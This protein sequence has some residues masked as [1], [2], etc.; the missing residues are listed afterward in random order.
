VLLNAILFPQSSCDS[1]V[2]SPKHFAVLFFH[3]LH[4]LWEEML[5]I[6]WDYTH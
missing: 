3:P 5:L 2:A 6:P 1:H 4:T